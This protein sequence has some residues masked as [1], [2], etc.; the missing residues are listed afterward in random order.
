MRWDPWILFPVCFQLVDIVESGQ[1]NLETIRMRLMRSTIA[2]TSVLPDYNG[3][4]SAIPTETMAIL[5]RE[6]YFLSWFIISLYSSFYNIFTTESRRFPLLL[7]HI[8]SLFRAGHFLFQHALLHSLQHSSTVSCQCPW[9]YSSGTRRSWFTTKCWVP[10]YVFS[11]DCL[12]TRQSLTS[13]KWIMHW[14]AIVR[15][16][17]LVNKTRPSFGIPRL[18]RTS[19]MS[20]DGQS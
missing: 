20:V 7:P 6:R 2:A 10:R 4:C 13:Q 9:C 1:F 18:L 14:H 16:S 19:S 8:H 3:I 12:V 15:I 5:K 11:N 17:T